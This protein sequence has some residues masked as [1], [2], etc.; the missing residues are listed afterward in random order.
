MRKNAA[1]Y[2]VQSDPTCNRNFG[3]RWAEAPLRKPATAAAEPIRLI[4][5]PNA[6][7]VDG[8]PRAALLVPPE[9]SAISR[10][11]VIRIF[12]SISA[13]IAAKRSLEAGR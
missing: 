1:D 12:A 9:P 2:A 6:L 3:R 11:P 10:R 5:V 7:D 8:L 4:A 13:A